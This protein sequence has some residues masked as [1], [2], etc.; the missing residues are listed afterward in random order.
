[1]AVFTMVIALY[2]KPHADPRDG[3]I[4][5]AGSLIIFLSMF[6]SLAQ[7]TDVSSETHDSQKAFA[8]VLLVLNAVM[9]AAAVF[10]VVL[11][12]VRALRIAKEKEQHG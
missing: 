8:A 2:Y 12:G 11:I 10:Q 9:G 3:Q 7:K 1:M 5:T 6:L 4:Y